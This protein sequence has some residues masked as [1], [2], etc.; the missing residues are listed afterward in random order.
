[1]E[2]ILEVVQIIPLV[3][4]SESVVDELVPQKWKDIVRA[5]IEVVLRDPA[6]PLT[7]R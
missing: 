1:M 2:E 4:D 7:G 5:R 6:R 3:R